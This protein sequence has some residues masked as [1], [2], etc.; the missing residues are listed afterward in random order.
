M[1]T[2]MLNCSMVGMP[3]YWKWTI[4]VACGVLSCFAPQML[5]DYPPVA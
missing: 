3:H 2:K 4:F 1:E 5:P